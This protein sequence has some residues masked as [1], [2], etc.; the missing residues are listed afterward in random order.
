MNFPGILGWFMNNRILKR[1]EESAAQI[2]FY[3]RFIVPWL[4]RLESVVRPPIGLSLVCVARTA[5][6]ERAAA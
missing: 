4:R 1:Q 2:K 3:D 5:L 6:R